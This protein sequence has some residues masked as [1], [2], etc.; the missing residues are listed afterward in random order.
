MDRVCS[1]KAIN[2]KEGRRLRAWELFQSGWEQCHIAEA[3]GV[4]KGAIS[5]WL[6]KA[7]TH[8][9]AALLHRKPPGPRSKLTEEQRSLLPQL[10]Q[11]GAEAW[12]FQGQVWTQPRVAEV[13]R[14]EFGVS[15]HPSQLG[16]IL[17]GFRWSRQKP[18]RRAAQRDEAAIKRW[19]EERWPEVKKKLPGKAG[20]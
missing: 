2:W 17:R 19:K 15:Y 12:G 20:P 16:V 9:P 7:R 13:V 5:Q 11:R 8:G 10:L 6:K 3:M 4:T 1:Q 18:M 14:R